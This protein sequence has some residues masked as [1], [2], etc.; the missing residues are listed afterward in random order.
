LPSHSLA[1]LQMKL[2]SIPKGRSD[3]SI[4]HV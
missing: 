2:L 1:L 3:L 4:F